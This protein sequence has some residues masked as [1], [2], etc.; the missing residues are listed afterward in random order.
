MIRRIAAQ[1]LPFFFVAALLLPIIAEAQG[2]RPVVPDDCTG[3]GGCKTICDFPKLAQNIFVDTVY[4]A[5][6]G[7]A[8]LFVWDGFKF[9]TAITRGEAPELV[10]AKSIAKHIVLGLIG[11]FAAWLAVNVIAGFVLTGT[12][13]PWYQLLCT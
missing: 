11:I 9:L 7:A 12:S 6:F 10:T 1:L 3:T 8:V 2:L 5:V 4:I 13:T